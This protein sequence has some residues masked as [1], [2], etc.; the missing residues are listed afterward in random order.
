MSNHKERGQFAELAPELINDLVQTFI[1]RT[2]C[3]A[4]QSADGCAYICIK[5]PLSDELVKAHIRG[6]LTLGTYVLDKDSNARWLC[7]DADDKQTWETLIITS[8]SLADQNI[9]SYLEASRRGG[10]LWMFTDPL[11]G[12]LVRQLGKAILSQYDLE[13]IELYPKQDK[14]TTGVGSLVRLPFGLH[15]KTG[16]RYP[17]ITPNGEPLAPTIREQIKLLSSPIRVP[18]DYI[19]HT[20]EIFVKIQQPKYIAPLPH[21]RKRHIIFASGETLS[22][23]IKHSI[24]VYDFV[25]RYV[26]LD[27]RDRGLCPFHD[28]QVQSFQV[29]RER[30]FW[31]CYAGCSGGSVIDFWMKWRKLYGQD[32]SFTATIKDLAQMLL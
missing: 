32:G 18:P 26:Q 2:D 8:R 14:L 28:D 4:L 7:L 13:R 11:P 12:H 10:H 19:S 31:H 22:E 1:S 5:R 29:H 6:V 30:N 9:T 21:P 15:R 27:N 24:S 25:S 17:F 20:T 23:K 3:Y 16:R